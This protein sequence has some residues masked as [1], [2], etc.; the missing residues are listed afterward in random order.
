MPRVTWRDVQYAREQHFYTKLHP[1]LKDLRDKYRQFAETTQQLERE[2]FKHLS[3]SVRI[4]TFEPVSGLVEKLNHRLGTDLR[5]NL[6]LFQAPV[7]NAM[8]AARHTDPDKNAAG[9]VVVLV[10]Q[11][12]LNE[13]SP[14]EVMSVLGHELGHLLFGH[15]HIPAQAILQS[16]FSLADIGGL[17]ADVLKWLTCCEISCDM[18]GFLGCDQ[19]LP[20]FSRAMLKYMTGLADRGIVVDRG[21]DGLVAL[22]LDQLE[23]VSQAAFDPTLTTHPL[24]P[25]RLRLAEAVASSQLVQH[26][27]QSVP[28]DDLAKYK[29]EFNSLIDAEI[30]KI[31]PEIFPRPEATDTDVRFELSTAVALADGKIT[32]DEIQAIG[33][34]LDRKVDPAA[35]RRVTETVRSCKPDLAVGRL[36]DE[37]VRLSQ[38]RRYSK[39]QVLGILKDLLIVA[40]SDGTTERCELEAIFSYARHFGITKQQIVALMGQ[41]GLV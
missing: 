9:E 30:R 6:F 13:L 34:V 28:A 36:V 14:E 23:E 37:A 7:A 19:R 3:N 24:T 18:I 38:Q 12:F 11:H 8:C 17:K 32:P 41:M 22:L 31:Y 16:K 2:F 40:A 4:D 15:V 35:Q 26:F 29:G 5:I 27:G 25:L 21:V 20:A 1:V 39:P 10:T 33:K